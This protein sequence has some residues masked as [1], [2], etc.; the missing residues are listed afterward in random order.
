MLQGTSSPDPRGALRYANLG[1]VVPG[2]WNIRDAYVKDVK[3]RKVI[4]F[5]RSNLHV[6]GYSSPFIGLYRSTLR[7]HLFT[8]LTDPEGSTRPCTTKRVGG[9][10]S[11]IATICLKRASTSL[12]RLD[13][14]GRLPDLWGTL[15][16]GG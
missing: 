3:G 14:G 12:H 11:A 13:P 15:P 9:S 6:A 8:C 1:L 10:V 16:A 2:E 7:S 5:Q 4:D